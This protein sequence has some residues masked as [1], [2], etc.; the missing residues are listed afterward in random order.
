MPKDI[1]TDLT[2]H[3]IILIE[4]GLSYLIKSFIH[5]DQLLIRNYFV[6]PFPGGDLR[7]VRDDA[8]GRV[9]G[10]VQLRRESLPVRQRECP[11]F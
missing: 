11:A 6:L 2:E 8:E 1:Y 4:F 5:C 3:T 7:A 10:Q 9:Q